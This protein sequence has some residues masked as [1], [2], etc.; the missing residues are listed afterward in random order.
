MF[1][2]GICYIYIPHALFF[3][4][5]E[6]VRCYIT[7]STSQGLV[8]AEMTGEVQRRS[9][10]LRPAAQLTAMEVVTARRRFIVADAGGDKVS[11]S[12]CCMQTFS[13]LA[14][15][16]GASG[17]CVSGNAGITVGIVLGAP[18]PLSLPPCC[19][20]LTSGTASGYSCLRRHT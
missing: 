10:Q 18:S 19:I 20:L 8:V 12:A 13:S 14:F 4:L 11:E 17:G 9:C 15:V 2:P 16:S 7:S 5:S 6:S 3:L 1:L